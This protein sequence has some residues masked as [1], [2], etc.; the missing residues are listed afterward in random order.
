MARHRSYNIEFKRQV[1]QEF[2]GGEFLRRIGQASRCGI[3]ALFE[4]AGTLVI[5]GPVGR[6]SR[7]DAG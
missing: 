5:A 1:A 7:E 4:S 6:P 2:L 3:A